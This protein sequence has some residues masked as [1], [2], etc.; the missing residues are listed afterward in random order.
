MN[1]PRLRAPI[2]LAHGLFGFDRMGMGSL[3]LDYFNGIP[4]VL[5]AAGNRVLTPRVSPL[6]CIAARAAQL[7]AFLD[8]EAP[9]EAVHIFGHSMGGLDA[10]YL[11]SR[12]DMASRIL[13][14]TTIGTPHQG[15]S[16]ADWS[17]QRFRLL[18]QPLFHF[19]G[20]PHEAFFDLTVA[21]C[22]RFNEEVPNAPGVRYLSVAGRLGRQ[23]FDWR[24]QLPSRIVAEAEG[25]NDGV[26]SIASAR[27]GEGCILW[28][29]DHMHLV[30]WSL[31][32]SNQPDRVPDY[33]RLVQR[34][35]DE[36][37]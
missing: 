28:E 4:P 18:Y 25:D 7:K 11:I 14:L 32:G 12:L 30:N 27:Y 19:L 1:A 2:L 26:V 23:G 29:G 36:G 21:C 8:L 16:F 37:F 6:A 35:K 20:V 34:L 22:R 15:S 3:A 17:V 31:A 9:G 13:S 24:W 10:R 33:V 5:R